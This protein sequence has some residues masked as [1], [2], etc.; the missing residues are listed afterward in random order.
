MLLA[1]LVKLVKGS[2]EWSE[3]SFSTLWG[4]YFDFFLKYQLAIQY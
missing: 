2:S 1:L 3:F 4:S